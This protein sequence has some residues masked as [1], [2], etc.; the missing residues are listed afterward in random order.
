MRH[1]HLWRLRG[2]GVGQKANG[3]HSADKNRRQNGPEGGPAEGKHPLDPLLHP[4]LSEGHGTG[5]EKAAAGA[6]IE[7]G[8]RIICPVGRGK[9]TGDL[10]VTGQLHVPAEQGVAQPQQGLEPV[11]T[12]Q[13]EAQ[14][15]PQ[16][17]PAPDVGALVGDDV[18]HILPGE[19]VRQINPR[20]EDTQHKGCGNGCALIEIPVNPNRPFHPAGKPPIADEGVQRH[21]RQPCAPEDGSRRD[22]FLR[23]GG[24]DG[25]PVGKH[26]FQ[27]RRD[28]GFRGIGRHFHRRHGVPD[29]LR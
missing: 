24:G 7:Q 22:D 23:R 6:A 5:G 16:G 14:R 11:D 15:L 29:R 10:F 13:A 28:G 2:D 21:P 26:R 25:E 4:H 3:D 18:G 12:E 9:G 27:N 8:L 1:R 19:G 20:A 17:V